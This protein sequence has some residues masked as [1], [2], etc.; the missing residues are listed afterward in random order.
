MQLEQMS[1]WEISSVLGVGQ[2]IDLRIYFRSSRKSGEL[3]KKEMDK[4]VNKK[5][6]EK[7]IIGAIIAQ[8]R[9]VRHL[10]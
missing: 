8:V 9:N 6:E 10:P 2:G 1:Q 4:L 3:C 7:N 5:L